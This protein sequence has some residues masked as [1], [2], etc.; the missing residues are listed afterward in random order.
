MDEAEFAEL[1]DDITLTTS[2]E[3]HNIMA[4]AWGDKVRKR[5]VSSHS[6]SIQENLLT[7]GD[8][9]KCFDEGGEETGLQ[10]NSETVETY[11]D[12][13]SIISINNRMRQG[14]LACHRPMSSLTSFAR[15]AHRK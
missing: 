1:G 7:N 4:H 10:Q 14:G 9:G 15:L 2:V 12:A 8:G 5:F 6:T 11:F 13:A 3:E